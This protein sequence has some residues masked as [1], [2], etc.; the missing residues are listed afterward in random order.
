MIDIGTSPGTTN[1]SRIEVNAAHPGTTLLIGSG[2][3][4]GPSRKIDVFEDVRVWGN[5]RAGEVHVVRLRFEQ[6]V[7]GTITQGVDDE[8]P[9]ILKLSGDARLHIVGGGPLNGPS[10][11]VVL[12]DDVRVTNDLV[13]ANDA[14]VTNDATVGNDLTVT[15]DTTVG[16]DLTVQGDAAV[17]GST[18]STGN[19]I[20]AGV[21]GAALNVKVNSVN[22]TTNSGTGTETLTGAIPA[23]AQVLGVVARV[24]TILAGAGLTTWDLGDTDDDRY[25]AALALAAGTTVDHTD[26]TADPEGTWSASARDLV[27]TANAGVFDSGAVNIQVFY[28]DTSAPTS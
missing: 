23:G 22:K 2:D 5:A 18:T 4:G 14:T 21:N 8:V 6:G 28:V 20:K 3:I 24:T 13:V 10:R 11:D 26:Y 1:T 15:N 25:G 7:D 16:V 17:T 9:R 19:L 27:L 12:W